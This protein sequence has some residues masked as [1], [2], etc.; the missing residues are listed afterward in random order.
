MRF[1]KRRVWYFLFSSYYN[2]EQTTNNNYKA[3]HPTI[4]HWYIFVPLPSYFPF[5]VNF[6]KGQWCNK[7]WP[8]NIISQ[9]IYKVL[10]VLRKG[11]NSDTIT[12]VMPI[13][14]KVLIRGSYFR[15]S[16]FALL[17]PNISR[18]SNVTS[19]LNSFPWTMA[20]C[21]LESLPAKVIISLLVLLL[22][23]MP[24]S[25]TFQSSCITG[26]IG[27]NLFLLKYESSL[28]MKHSSKSQV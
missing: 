18:K 8:D 1:E 12:N 19:F 10:I 6:N 9:T 20:S 27:I 5:M 11:Q 28:S 22:I 2:I 16:C 17:I 25:F 14:P 15:L 23:F 4:F 21:I 24:S 3:Y 13:M 26:L 7:T